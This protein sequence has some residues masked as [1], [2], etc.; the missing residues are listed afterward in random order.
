M[1]PKPQL[2]DMIRTVPEVA[3]RLWSGGQVSPFDD[4]VRILFENRE[5]TV[6]QEIFDQAEK[7][8]KILAVRW[9]GKMLRGII[10][11]LELR[12][13]AE[14]VFLENVFHKENVPSVLFIPAGVVHAVNPWVKKS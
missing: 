5:I 9:G 2:I 3:V 10:D 14:D 11:V 13:A 6:A 4:G 8:A 12:H 7:V 1:P